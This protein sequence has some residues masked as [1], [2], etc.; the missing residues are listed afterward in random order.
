MICEL[1]EILRTYELITRLPLQMQVS[2]TV[3]P[4]RGLLLKVLEA[5][6]TVLP[7]Q[8]KIIHLIEAIYVLPYQFSHFSSG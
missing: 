2:S 6:S 3:P 8:H 4:P 7:I 5:F 1:V